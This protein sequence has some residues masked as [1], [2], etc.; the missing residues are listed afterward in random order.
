MPHPSRVLS[1]T[2]TILPLPPSS[3]P[4]LWILLSNSLEAFLLFQLPVFT[5]TNIAFAQ[6]TCTDRTA[7]TSPGHERKDFARSGVKH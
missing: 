7:P 5:V 6:P 4:W 3:M 2:S 1:S